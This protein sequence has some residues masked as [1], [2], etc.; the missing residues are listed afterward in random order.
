MSP[1]YEDNLERERAYRAECIEGGRECLATRDASRLFGVDEGAIS[2]AK[3]DG[4]LRPVF[5][6]AFRNL[7]IF[8][9]ADLR[10]YF[11]GR[12]EPDPT[13]LATMR[14]HGPT[15]FV[16]AAG[17]GWLLLTERPGLRTWEEAA[18]R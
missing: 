12:A 5:V 11:A 2:V 17:G 7:P 4:R 3:H 16:Q 13:L 15:C 6:L 14:S 18:G 10:D 9:L 8:R 1:A